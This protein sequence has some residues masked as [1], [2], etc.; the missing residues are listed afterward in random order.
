MNYPDKCAV[1]GHPNPQVLE[2]IK[3]QAEDGHPVMNY[4]EIG[5]YDGD[6]TI[7]VAH[8]LQPGATIQL[9]DFDYRVKA[10]ENRLKAD[11]GLE[12]KELFVRLTPNTDLVYDSYNWSLAHCL[13]EQLEYDF[14]YID[15]A[16][17]WN[18][19]AMAFLL[20]D[21]MLKPGGIIAFD[22]HS[23]AIALSKTMSPEAFPEVVEQYTQDQIEALQVQMI[24]DL[25]VKPDPRYVE[26]IPNFAYQ[27][28]VPIVDRPSDNG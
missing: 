13:I 4:A 10:V 11:P 25:L 2:L 6:T 12:K 5:I 7:A 3:A 23:W 15:G 26:V 9:F 22:D 28:V 17:T 8:A 27:K 21:K 20:A 19:D 14:V 1:T 18:H 16:H 24:I